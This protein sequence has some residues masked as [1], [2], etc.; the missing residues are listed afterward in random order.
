[1]GELDHVSAHRLDC[2]SIIDMEIN[3]CMAEK[4]KQEKNGIG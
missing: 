1:M 2:F 3:A 4:A